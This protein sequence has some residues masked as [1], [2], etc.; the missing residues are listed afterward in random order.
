MRIKQTVILIAALCILVTMNAYA[1][2]GDVSVWGNMG[3]GTSPSSTYRLYV[4][5]P[6]Y[7]TIVWQ[8][9]DLS[10]KENVEP[11]ASPLQKLRNVQGVSFTWKQEGNEHRGFPGGKH[12]GVVAQDVQKVFPE[13]VQDGPEGEKAVAYSEL[14]P[15]LIEAMKEQQNLIEGQ[16]KDIQELKT[17]LKNMKPSGK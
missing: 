12:I 3:I 8:S 2:N 11:I 10:L 4:Y 7:A 9:S 6:A 13:V 15:I 17:A 5:G 1:A 16:Q 14:I